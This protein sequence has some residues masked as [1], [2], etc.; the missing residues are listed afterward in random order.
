MTIKEVEQFLIAAGLPPGDGF[1]VL[2]GGMGPGE[3]FAIQ[4]DGNVWQV[5]YSERG[6]KKQL[7]VFATEEEAVH[8]FLFCILEALVGEYKDSHPEIYDNKS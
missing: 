3:C 6:M 5:F 1:Y 8:Y 2:D 4:Y 7:R